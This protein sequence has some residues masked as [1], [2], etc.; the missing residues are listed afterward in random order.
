MTPRSDER[1]QR[2]LAL[3]SLVSSAPDALIDAAAARRHLNCTER[4]LDESIELISTLADRESGARAIIYRDHGD[5]VLAGEASQLMPLRLSAG[6]GAVLSYVIDELD[7]DPDTRDRLDRALLPSMFDAERTRPFASTASFG[8]WHATLARACA[9][10]L[11]CIIS[12]RSHEEAEPISRIVD[13]V[14]I[15]ATRD[16]AYLVAYNVEKRA[17]RRYR[18]DRIS[19]AHMTDTPVATTLLKE[20]D[21]TASLAESLAT[22]EG[23]AELSLAAGAEVPNWTGVVSV[24]EDAAGSHTVR[25]HLAS[26][27]WLFDQVLG[28]GGTLRITAPADLVDEFCTYA[29]AL[30]S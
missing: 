27:H 21:W 5:I 1:V 10:G 29:R 22:V 18:L 15:E 20:D 19:A 26:K 14:R 7:L 4:E 30:L 11:R 17:L 16:A 6:E 9:K 25:V 3:L 8:A 12:Y 24:T 23:V 28:S 13:P 2:A